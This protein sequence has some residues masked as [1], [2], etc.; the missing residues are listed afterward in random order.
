MTYTLA[1]QLTIKFSYDWEHQAHTVS[2]FLF[3]GVCEGVIHSK[4]YDLTAATFVISIPTEYIS[5]SIV[6]LSIDSF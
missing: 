4:K 2:L 5:I 3:K 1:N 6:F